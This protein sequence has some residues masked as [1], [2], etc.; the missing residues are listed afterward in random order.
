[1]PTMVGYAR[2][3]TDTQDLTAQESQLAAM[4][5]A[6]DRIY[7][8]KG[9]SGTRRDRPGL[10]QA[11]AA[12]REGD[13]FVVTKLDR[14]ARSVPDALEIM[15]KLSDRRVKFSMGGSVYDWADEYAKMFLT[16]LAAIAEFEAGIIRQRTREGMA[17]ARLKG[18]LR[19]RQPKLSSARQAL[20]RQEH[21]SGKYNI[22]ELAELFE[23]SR[24]T[25]YRV[26]AR[27]LTNAGD[28]PAGVNDRRRSRPR[29]A[30]VP[31]AL[32]QT[33]SSTGPEEP[34]VLPQ[35]D[36]VDPGALLAVPGVPGDED[37]DAMG[38]DGVHD[39]GIPMGA[40]VP[41]EVRDGYDEKDLDDHYEQEAWADALDK[42]YGNALPSTRAEEV[43]ERLRTMSLS[44]AMEEAR[45]TA[46]SYRP[47]RPAV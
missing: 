30:T 6:E 10:D 46:R 11:L 42:K 8:D 38:V 5:V 29:R 44:E 25:V 9:V 7:T 18:K 41:G 15:K 37:M 27:S 12:V 32:P 34:G 26:L 47:R 2:C 4:G 3:S 23:V 28:A 21:A 36:V 31:G 17:I 13:T 43:P 22:V 33:M 35:Q 16:I 45:R 40:N 19:G 1:M 24:P 20:L 14:L 39:Q